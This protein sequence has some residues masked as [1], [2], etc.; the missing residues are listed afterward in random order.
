MDL[1]LLVIGLILWL[2]GDNHRDDV[3][4]LLER[5]LA[6]AAVMVVLLGGRWLLLEGAALAL[7]L[8]LPSASRFE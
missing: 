5:I 1:I 6:V 2:L 7:A 3:I 8:W 4:G